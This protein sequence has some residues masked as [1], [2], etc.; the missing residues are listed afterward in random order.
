MIRSFFQRAPA[1]TRRHVVGLC[2]PAFDPAKFLCKAVIFPR[3][4]GKK[5]RASPGMRL[6]R[7][8]FPPKAP[9]PR[10]A[11]ACL[12]NRKAYRPYV[13]CALKQNGRFFTRQTSVTHPTGCDPSSP[14]C[15]PSPP[16]YRVSYRLRKPSQSLCALAYRSPPTPVSLFVSRCAFLPPPLVLRRGTRIHSAQRPAK[17]L[18]LHCG[19]HGCP[20]LPMAQHRVGAVGKQIL[21]LF[22][23]LW[24][25]PQFCLFFRR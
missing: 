5:D 4:A 11:F 3:C 21:G 20:R 15:L 16:R 7:F 2:K 25:N 10:E 17:R 22:V 24:E 9:T 6:D 19:R 1:T 23:P 13:A 18:Y 12:Q 8:L 14:R